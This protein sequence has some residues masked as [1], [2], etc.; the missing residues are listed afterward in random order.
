[1]T[2][3]TAPFN[4]A[5]LS[6][7]F[8]DR[9]SQI[10]CLQQGSSLVRFHRKA[11]YP[12]KRIFY[13]ILETGEIVWTK[14]A[15]DWNNIEGRIDLRLVKEVRSTKSTLFND[16][17][18]DNANEQLCFT[19][20]YGD[21]FVLKELACIATSKIE[22]DRWV[23][24]IRFLV[25]QMSELIYPVRVHRWLAKQFRMLAACSA[26][27]LDNPQTSAINSTLSPRIVTLDQ[28]RITE[29]DLKI[30]LARLNYK[31]TTRKLREHMTYIDADFY[32]RPSQLVDFEMFRKLH[33]RM[34]SANNSSIYSILPIIDS[35]S[36]SRSSNSNPSISSEIL[37]LADLLNFLEQ[38]NGL[39]CGRDIKGTEYFKNLL[40]D[41]VDDG[42]IC[43]QRINSISISQ[44][45]LIDFLY[46]PENSIWDKSLDVPHDMT[47]PLTHYW[48]ASSHNTYLTGDQIMS[49]S[50]SDAYARALRMGCR[51][52]EIDCWDGS[53]GMPIIYHG[54]TATTKI[55]FCDVLKT[56]RDHAFETSSY[57]VVLSVEN[58]CSLDQQRKM[59]EAF[60]R[61]LGDKLVKEPYETNECM[62]S[63]KELEFKII[64]KHKKLPDAD[65][66]LSSEQQVCQTT[67]EMANIARTLQVENSADDSNGFI[68]G[69]CLD[70]QDEN[71]SKLWTSNYFVL[72]RDG[73]F[74]TDKVDTQDGPS[75]DV[76]DHDDNSLNNFKSLQDGCRKLRHQT[77]S[78]SSSSG[79]SGRM[80]DF[81]P[82]HILPRHDTIKWHPGAQRIGDR[83]MAEEILNQQSHLGDGAFLIRGSNTFTTSF[84]LS[85]MHKSKI[86]HIKVNTSTNDYG[87]ERY[88][89]SKQVT[90][91]NL[92]SLVDYYQR[93]PLKS[94][95]VVQ[96]LVEPILEQN[97]H[98][99]AHLEMEWFHQDMN[100]LRAEE[101]LRHFTSGSFLVRPSEAEEDH[102]SV[103]FV[104]GQVIKHCR[105]KFD[106]NTYLF[107][108][109][110]KFTT[111]VEL[112]QHF[113]KHYIYMRT[114]LKNPITQI[115]LADNIK[116]DTM[117]GDRRNSES[118]P[119]RI[120][121]SVV[122]FMSITPKLSL[123]KMCYSLLCSNQD[124][125]DYFGPI[126]SQTL[127][128]NVEPCQY[129]SPEDNF[130]TLNGSSEKSFFDRKDGCNWWNRIKYD[131]DGS[132]NGGKLSSRSSSGEFDPYDLH[133]SIAAR[134]NYAN[135]E[136]KPNADHQA[137]VF[138]SHN[139]DR[140]K[141]FEI[142]E[143]T[144]ISLL[145]ELPNET[146]QG[147]SI[148]TY[149]EQ[150][151]NQYQ[152]NLAAR[153]PEVRDEWVTA[154]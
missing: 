47:R 82:E 138:G 102:Y 53:D 76:R 14:K 112:V 100:R 116:C 27:N 153:L 56:I 59:A 92:A 16:Q 97:L 124:P 133:E 49:K 57:P 91:D 11:K 93:N 30:F 29:K 65:L 33:Q 89:L 51:C 101:C 80:I 25:V 143:T 52:I 18:P 46:S 95:D 142:S 119:S 66:K 107:G 120:I 146:G 72:T 131:S 115:M 132:S 87:H 125:C 144:C 45:E 139:A 26:L 96:I 136:G 75:H 62:P 145:D 9:E 39:V 24:C 68:L 42:N 150:T 35:D 105:V 141:F 40:E 34:I 21:K 137:D 135:D 109:F 54:H 122:K 88:F 55:K 4:A 111:L 151:N 90:F 22:R 60:T 31:I 69:G 83:Q 113:R 63:P 149:S 86:H 123:L 85:F 37:S 7:S 61:I 81:E 121:G 147:F 154:L 2:R 15:L 71:D 10:Q 13:V 98:R 108:M 8:T 74:Y 110:D 17:Y 127:E 106:K 48:I 50:S 5:A 3:E 32:Q 44:S 126:K 130:L 78:V 58:H 77:S 20:L 128:E 84:T 23:D 38:E 104:S 117:S 19:I 152:L 148:S 118:S 134:D 140:I 6:P 70:K 114:K 12:E 41:Y 36:H 103:S 64:I 99:S 129:F 28:L 67:P 43:E 1:M 94:N 79:E 73:L